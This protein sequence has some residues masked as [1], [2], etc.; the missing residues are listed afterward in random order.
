M[1]LGNMTSQFFANVYLNELDYFIKHTLKM[2]Y[3]LRYVD[4]FVILHEDKEKLQECKNKIESYLTSIKLELHQN[5]SKIF[6]MHRGVGLLGFRVFYY[7]KLLRKRN[8]VQFWKHL[9]DL[10]DQYAKELI[11][12]IK[13]L[14]YVQGWFSYAMW[15]NTH[16]LR[17]N[18][19]RRIDKLI[20]ESKN[21]SNYSQRILVIEKTY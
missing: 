9:E 21:E 2:K 15:G 4:D 6:P 7:Y 5:K 16:K 17:K 1:P 10:E 20:Q 8:L 19:R 13:L 18:I 12:K 14:I 3:Y 11:S